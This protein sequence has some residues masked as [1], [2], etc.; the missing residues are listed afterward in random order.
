MAK[1]DEAAVATAVQDLEAAVQGDAD[2]KLK[3]LQTLNDLVDEADEGYTVQREAAQNGA[4]NLLMQLLEDDA[5]SVRVEAAKALT[6][7][8]QHSPSAMS[9]VRVGK[10]T[11]FSQTPEKVITSYFSLTDC[12]LSGRDIQAAQLSNSEVI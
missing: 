9:R 11:G 1:F 2:S 12:D 4:L 6:V 5:G 10:T 8:C 7:L 3:A